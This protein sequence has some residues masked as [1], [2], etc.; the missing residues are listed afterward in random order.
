VSAVVSVVAW[1]YTQHKQASDN[2]DAATV[3][4]TRIESL[5]PSMQQLGAW[6]AAR[7]QTVIEVS[8]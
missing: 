7:A 8:V 6:L 2:D 1:A 4:L 5:A 3:L